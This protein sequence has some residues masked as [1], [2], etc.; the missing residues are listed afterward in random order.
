M[1]CELYVE[2]VDDFKGGQLRLRVV[3]GL[4]IELFV[5]NSHGTFVGLDVGGAVSVEG[6]VSRLVSVLVE[7]SGGGVGGIGGT[8]VGSRV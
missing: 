7:G 6:Y 1:V 3:V 2:V 5:G 8:V 4:S